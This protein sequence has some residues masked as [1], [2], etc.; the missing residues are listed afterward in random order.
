MRMEKE[1]LLEA[2]TEYEVYLA[3]LNTRI[4]TDEAAHEPIVEGKWSV[5]EIIAHLGAWDRFMREERLPFMKEGADIE[6]LPDVDAFN[7]KAVEHVRNTEFPSVLANAQKQRA[8]L[9][10]AIEE[11]DPADFKAPF[12]VGSHQTDAADYF[13]GLLSHDAHHRRQI[14]AFLEKKA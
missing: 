8:L 5:S 9:A 1:Q 10:K 2:F 12:A 6:P 14:D 3:S 13:E 4:K 11:M 7:R